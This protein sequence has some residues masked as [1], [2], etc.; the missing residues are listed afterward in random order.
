MSISLDYVPR[1]WSGSS[2]I[3]F[4]IDTNGII[5]VAVLLLIGSQIGNIFTE[6]I[7][8]FQG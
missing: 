6:V 8:G 7:D 2:E 5:V 3:C 4:Y 1:C